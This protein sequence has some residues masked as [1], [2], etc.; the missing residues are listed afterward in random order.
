MTRGNSSH[1]NRFVASGLA[2]WA[3]WACFPGP[4]S[5][6]SLHA[7][8]R[9]TRATHEPACSSRRVGALRVGVSRTG[10]ES[11]SLLAPRFTPRLTLTVVADTSPLV[12]ALWV[13]LPQ[14]SP[15]QVFC[16]ASLPHFPQEDGLWCSRHRRAYFAWSLPPRGGTS[17]PRPPRG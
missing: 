14:A 7:S 13:F 1:V 3:H 10:P 6:S 9:A 5:S 8:R 11:E 17:G 15:P 16:R 12:T 2:D 4:S